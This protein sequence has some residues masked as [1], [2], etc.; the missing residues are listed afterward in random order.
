ML[1]SSIGQ[2]CQIRHNLLYPSFLDYL[3]YVLHL[4]LTY[5]QKQYLK[6]T[7]EQSPM[8]LLSLFSW[9]GISSPKS[10]RLSLD[11]NRG[12]EAGGITFAITAEADCFIPASLLFSHL[13]YRRNRLFK[14]SFILS[15][16]SNRPSLG[17]LFIN[18]TNLCC[19]LRQTAWSS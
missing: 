15:S 6:A 18:S 13:L 5:L 19:I 8:N 11:S 10:I 14:S 9:S 16:S 1:H 3:C 17:N 12:F 7:R 4:I 2:T